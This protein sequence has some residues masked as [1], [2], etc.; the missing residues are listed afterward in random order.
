MLTHNCL[1]D[2]LCCCRLLFI[3]WL[4]REHWAREDTRCDWLVLPPADTPG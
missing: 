3:T 2:L 1:V 4:A